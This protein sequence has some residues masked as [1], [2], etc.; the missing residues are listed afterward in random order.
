MTDGAPPASGAVSC[1]NCRQTLPAGAERCIWCGVPQ[2][3]GAAA[4]VTAPASYPGATA[5]GG[6]GSIG[7]SQPPS[8]APAYGTPASALVAPAV[9]PLRVAPPVDAALGPEF[10]GTVA[11]TGPR[12][13]AFAI[14]VVLVSVVATVVLAVTGSGAFAVLTV[15]ELVIGSWVM[16]A[17]TGATVGQRLL[18]LRTSRVEAP[19]SPGAAASLVRFALTGAGFAALGVGSWLIVA[20]GAWDPARRRRSFAD[21]ATRTII[22]AAPPRLAQ[23]AATTPLPGGVVAPPAG[24]PPL[25]APTGLLQPPA[26][27]IAAPPSVQVVAPPAAPLSAQPPVIPTVPVVTPASAAGLVA[28][29]APAAPAAPVAP[30]VIQTPPPPAVTPPPLVLADPQIISTR[31][32]STPI[33]DESASAQSPPLAPEEPIFETVAVQRPATPSRDALLLIFDTGQREQVALPAAINLGRNPVASQEGDALI[34][35]RDPDSTVS[36][37]HARVEHLDGQTWV[38]D[39][40]STNGTEVISDEGVITVLAPRVRTLLEDG[41][42][43]RIGKRAFT[44]SVLVGG[45]P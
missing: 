5:T 19:F 9:T 22:V 17:R 36:K 38:S 15:L 6:A 8:P 33:D 10:R 24:Q 7:A 23:P 4:L 32:P 31:R 14:D 35:V 13:A 11:G 21:R 39:G 41:A 42:R 26:P 44:V 1:W 40:G 18:R 45:T 37:T 12:V 20:S 3:A 27:S 2:T 30:P 28:P 43:I 25:V 34:S 29:V 16:Q